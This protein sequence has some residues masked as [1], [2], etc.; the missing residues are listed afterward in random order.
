M[1]NTDIPSG[2]DG[3]AFDPVALSL[4]FLLPSC[5]AVGFL[6][7]PSQLLER[8]PDSALGKNSPIFF[9]AVQPI[10]RC[11]NRFFAESFHKPVQRGFHRRGFV[12]GVA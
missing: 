11:R 7:G 12:E 3:E 10:P 8:I 9:R 4:H 1:T 5:L 6:F 2:I